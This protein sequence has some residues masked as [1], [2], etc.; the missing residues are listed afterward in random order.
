M[1]SLAQEEGSG[2]TAKHMLFK[3]YFSKNKRST[4]TAPKSLD[5]VNFRHWP[6]YLILPSRRQQLNYIFIG[7]DDASL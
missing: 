3:C 5:C 4:T 6:R 7:N 2:Q 1:L